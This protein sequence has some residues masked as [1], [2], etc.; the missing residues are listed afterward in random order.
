MPRFGPYFASGQNTWGQS[1]NLDGAQS[2]EVRRHIIDNALMWLRDFHVDGLRLDAVHALVDHRATHLLEELRRE[3][4]VLSAHLGRPLSLIAESDLNDTR[5]VT[6]WEAGGYGLHGVWDDDAHHAVHALITGER[7]GYYSDFGSLECLASVLTGAYFHAGTWSS[8]RERVHGRPVDR[9]NIPGHRFVVSLQNHDQ[10]GNRAT[11]DRLSATL[12]PA[13]LKVGAA[14]MLTSPFTPMLFM[15]EEWG[16]STPWQFF[17]S[18]PEPEL[19]EATANGRKR[20]FA[21]HGWDS[22]EVPDPQAPSTFTDSKLDWS[23]LD[24]DPH[25]EVLAFYRE[26]IAARKAYPD[27]SDPRLDEVRVTHNEVDRWLVIRRGRL[28]VAVNLAE[29]RQSVPL[30][31]APQEVVLASERWVVLTSHDVEMP[32]Q[33]V[34]ILDLG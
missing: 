1:F 4:E 7:Q 24:G 29:D 8:F 34:A 13:L 15:G 20:E 2:D 25:K 9:A 23:E 30:E 33:S 14:L 28:A 3:T 27:L 17:T 31:R 10:I 32:A 22:A 16:A 12:S 21:E 5:L 6:A 19:A 11:G 26:L 18:H